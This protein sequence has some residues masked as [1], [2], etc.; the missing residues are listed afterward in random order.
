VLLLPLLAARLRLRARLHVRARP[1]N[2]RDGPARVAV[3]AVAAAAAV[4]GT[5]WPSVSRPLVQ[6]L[7]P[8][9]ARYCS[10]QSQ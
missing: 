9:V 6:K 3:A 4:G 2:Q 5:R 7:L 10:V 1:T 8:A